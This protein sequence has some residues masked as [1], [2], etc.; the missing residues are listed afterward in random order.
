MASRKHIPAAVCRSGSRVVVKL[1]GAC[2]A[3]LCERVQVCVAAL[4]KPLTSDLY[5]DL[6][7]AD[8]LDSTFAGFLVS[9]ATGKAGPT[10]PDIHLLNLSE[11][12]A[13]SLSNIHVL[14]LFDVPDAAPVLPAEWQ[15]LPAEPVDVA[16]VRRLVIDSHEALIEADERNAT[17]FQH[18]VDLFRANQPPNADSHSPD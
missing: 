11:G 8:W 10:M 12:A 18:V 4:S 5:F 7:E 17:T 6:A 2:T 9:L 13:Q 1:S 16:R 3:T 14:R 15:E